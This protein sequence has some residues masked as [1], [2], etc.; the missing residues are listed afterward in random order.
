MASRCRDAIA[1][2]P[3][4]LHPCL[5]RPPFF[6]LV[7]M[8]GTHMT[9]MEGNTFVIVRSAAHRPCAN[10]PLNKHRAIINPTLATP[11]T[12]HPN[13]YQCKGAHTYAHSQHITVL[14]HFV[15]IQY[16]CGMQSTELKHFVNM[17]HMDVGCS[18]KGF[19]ASTMTLLC[20][21]LENQLASNMTLQH[22]SGSA[23]PQ[24]S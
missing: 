23:I 24:L 18:P 12:T 13:R 4:Y 19:G 9:G 22:H 5:P 10:V 17:L 6:S 8:Y 7:M 14:K 21:G 11:T 16:G 3:V 15:N 20:R 1:G 2:N